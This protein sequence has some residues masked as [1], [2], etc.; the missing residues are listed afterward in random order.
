MHSGNTTTKHRPVVATGRKVKGRR[1]RKKRKE[2]RS[3]PN[4]IFGL[5]M[6]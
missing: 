2:K 4:M 1:R 6:I 3:V 5:S